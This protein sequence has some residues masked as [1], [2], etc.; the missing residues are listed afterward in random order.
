MIICAVIGN[1]WA[2]RK[3]E[4]FSGLKLMVVQQLD[5][6]G[7]RIGDAFVAADCVGAGAGERVLVVA[8]SS[9]RKALHNAE[10]PMDAAIVAIIDQVEISLP[11]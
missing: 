4:T 8:G 10:T 3:E 11:E 6:T 7:N 5:E 9:A 1:V 2:T